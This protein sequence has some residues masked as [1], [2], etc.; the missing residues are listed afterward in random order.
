[1]VVRITKQGYYWP[2][3]HRD[4]AR[5]IQD[6]EKCKE[7]SAVRKRTKIK[8]ITARNAW[9]FSHWGVSIL[10]PLPTAQRGH[11][12]LEIAIEHSTK[13]IEAKPLTTENARH[14][15]RFIWEYVRIENH[16]I[17]LPHHITHGD[18]KQNQEAINSKPTRMGGRFTLVEN[19]VAKDDRGRTKEV[20]KRKESKEVASIKEAYYQNELHMYHIKRSNHSTY[21]VGDFILLLQNNT[22]K[23]AVT[24]IEVKRNGA[25]QR[26][27]LQEETSDHRL[28]L[29][30]E[31]VP[32]CFVIFDLEPLSL[33]FDFVF[34]SEIFKSLSFCLD[35]L[36]HLAILCLDQ[37]AHT[38]HHLE[39]LLTISLDRLDIFEGRSCISEFVRKSDQSEESFRN[40]SLLSC[41]LEE[42]LL[43]PAL[44]LTVHCCG[45]EFRV[46]NCYDQKSFVV[47]ERGLN[48]CEQTSLA[49]DVSDI[50]LISSNLRWMD[51]TINLVLLL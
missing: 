44:N 29:R 41:L 19:N 5:I 49:T 23:P 45:R 48:C 46:L 33:S 8:A 36:C 39:S 13:W 27:H 14:I 50:S 11:K 10:G 1:M 18:N 31:L 35:R 2:L 12:F 24:F 25:S 22:E 43:E 32:S 40:F 17:F 4:I 37:H 16:I 7:Q 21:K 3:M 51:S 20:K 26:K 34:A 9:M 38:L 28:E 30:M 42:Q 15:E 47:E 6:C